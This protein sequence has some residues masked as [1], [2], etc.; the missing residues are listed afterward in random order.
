MKQGSTFIMIVNLDVDITQVD[1]VIFTLKNKDTILTKENWS[2]ENGKFK[3][4]FTQEETVLLEGR[5]QI[6]AQINF[7]NRSVAKSKIK[8]VY[9]GSTLAT[10]IIDDNIATDEQK[11]VSLD[12]DGDIVNIGSKNYEELDNKPSINGTTLIGDVSLDALNIASKEY[13]EEEIAK[14]DFIK[15]VTAL[16]DEGL[17]N[18]TYLVAKT[19]GADN[20]FYDEYIWTS[21]GWEYIGTKQIEVDLTDYVK[22][23]DLGVA[24]RTDSSGKV[25]LNGGVLTEALIKGKT[26]NQIPITPQFL[27][28]CVKYGLADSQ[29]EWTDEQKASALAL[30]GA[31]EN[32]VSKNI[33][34]AVARI[35][36]TNGNTNIPLYTYGASNADKLLCGSVNGY[37]LVEVSA[38]TRTQLEKQL[39]DYDE[40]KASLQSQVD[41]KVEKPVVPAHPSVITMDANGNILTTRYS[42]SGVAYTIVQR[43]GDGRIYSQTPKYD[44]HVTT[45]AY[46]DGLIADL[47]AQIDALKG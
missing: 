26:T 27:D 35:T 7:E 43:D 9:I 37:G 33:G 41:D 25:Q 15:I 32:I 34:V 11:E 23:T 16:P 44:S 28:L 31:Q 30:L 47:Q 18:R 17:P 46:V 39:G 21:N 24:F 29:I 8:D 45:K 38:I 13:V 42:S 6:E 4:P 14:F 20:D 36:G 22:K 2:Y 3:I 40:T 12:I 19:D 10:R 5:A 1:S